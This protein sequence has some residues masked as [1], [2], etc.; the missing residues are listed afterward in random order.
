MRKRKMRATAKVQRV[1]CRAHHI[2]W[3]RGLLIARE[4]RDIGWGEFQ[5]MMG[6]SERYLRYL[7]SGLRVGS[8]ETVRRLIEMTRERGIII[9][10]SD[11]YDDDPILK[12]EQIWQHWHDYKR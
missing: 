5:I 1:V 3:I 12:S 8:R 7:K 4:R 9:H 6:C 2:H 11:F 10:L